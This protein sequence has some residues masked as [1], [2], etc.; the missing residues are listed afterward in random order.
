MTPTLIAV[1]ERNPYWGPELRRELSRLDVRIAACDREQDVHSWL[2]DQAGQLVVA[3]SPEEQLPL[4]TLAKW[5]QR[6]VR[7]HV[8]LNS[9][10][11]SLRWFLM[12]LGA[13][14]VFGFDDA[15][16]HLARR[17]RDCSGLVPAIARTTS[18]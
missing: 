18:R 9:S 2:A 8:V 16:Q 1:W 5:I 7:V 14:T 13:A 17:V 10:Q 4:P 11:D 15:R 6:G 12:E 3:L